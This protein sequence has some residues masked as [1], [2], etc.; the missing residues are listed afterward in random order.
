[1]STLV[2]DRSN[3]GIR[4]DADALVLFDHGGRRSTVPINLLERVVLQGA[5]LELTSGALLRL[6]EQGAAVL[7]LSSRQSR[8]LAIVLGPRHND[9]AVRLAQARLVA[10]EEARRQWSLLLVRRKLQRQS[11]LLRRLRAVRPDA[12]RPLSAAITAIERALDG[13]QTNDLGLDSLRGHE[14]AAAARYFEALAAVFPPALGFAGRNR[15]PPRDPVNACLS[16]GYTLLHF[17][18][19]RAAHVAGLD[20]LLGL[21]HRPAFGRESLACDLIEPLRPMVDRWVWR[22]LADRILRSEHFR[23]DKGACLLG[24]AGRGHFY[25]AWEQ[26]AGPH[27]RLLRR[28]CALIARHLRCEGACWMEQIPGFDDDEAGAQ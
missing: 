6:A 12:R 4:H 9:A 7:F 11:A 24:K 13:L 15:R 25:S 23:R 8:Q 14:G 2:L 1:M 18:A 10:D 3:L 5:S 17:D 22:L 16:L 21:Y 27:R 28:Q 26:A 19:V 20:P